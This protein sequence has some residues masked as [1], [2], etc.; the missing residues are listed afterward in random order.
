MKIFEILND[1]SEKI[2]EFVIKY[3]DN[4]FF[5]GGAFLLG[6]GIFFL[7]YSALNKER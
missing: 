5:W 6:L 3:G 7:T 1:F 4:P 2:K